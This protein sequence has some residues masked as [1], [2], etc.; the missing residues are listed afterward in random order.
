VDNQ[1]IDKWFDKV[2]KRKGTK[3]D[4]EFVFTIDPKEIE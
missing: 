3:E 2:F 1:D 4:D